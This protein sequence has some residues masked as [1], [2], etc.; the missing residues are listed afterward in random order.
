M[1]TIEHHPVDPYLGGGGATAGHA[2]VHAPLQT[3]PCVE[4]CRACVLTLLYNICFDSTEHELH[5]PLSFLQART[6][7]PGGGSETATTPDPRQQGKQSARERHNFGMFSVCNHTTAASCPL[8]GAR[9]RCEATREADQP[10]M[11]R[12][13]PP[14]VTPIW[15]TAYAGRCRYVKYTAS[16]IVVLSSLDDCNI[17][18]G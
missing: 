16:P 3:H 5:D 10:C 11:S 14:Q 7:Q 13:P 1:A 18:V 15:R 17:G 4:A 6:G 12:R 9:C 2:G 8:A